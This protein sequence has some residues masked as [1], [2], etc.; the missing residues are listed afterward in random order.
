MEYS[1]PVILR[2]IESPVYSQQIDDLLSPEDHRQ[3]QLCLLECPD[4]GDL[5]KGSGGLRKLKWAGSGCG[6]RGGIRVIYYLWRGDTAF[7]L[8]AFPKN[9]QTDLTPSQLRALRE[10]IEEYTNER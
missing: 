7:M 10:L 5:I 1:A 6:K 9:R 3:L 2:F 8:T 4:Q